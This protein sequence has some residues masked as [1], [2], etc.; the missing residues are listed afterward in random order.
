MNRYVIPLTIVVVLSGLMLAFSG[1][2]LADYLQ[3]QKPQGRQQRAN[4]AVVGPGGPQQLPRL[5]Q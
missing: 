5:L 1:V 2:W 3:H 4:H